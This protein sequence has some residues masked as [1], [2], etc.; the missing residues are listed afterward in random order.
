LGVKH[1]SYIF[2]EP[3]R[4]NIGEILKVISYFPRMLEDEDNEELFKEVSREEL[5]KFLSSFQKDRCPGPDRWLVEFYLDFFE[6]IG[7]DLLRIMEEVRLAGNVPRNFN[8]TFIALIPKQ[9]FPKKFDGFR[10]ISLC[11][12][13]YKIISKII[14]LRLKPLLSRYISP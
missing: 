6:F 3:E 8:S 13:V 7:D 14:A 5:S 2:K 1:F 4:A 9:D 11:N 12:C 10:L